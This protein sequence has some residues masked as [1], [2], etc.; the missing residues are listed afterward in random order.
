MSDP[1]VEIGQGK[2]KGHILKDDL[3]NTYYTFRGIPYA[4]PPIGELRFAAPEPPEPW[5]GIKDGSKECNICA[6]FDVKAKVFVGDEDCL[7]LNVSMRKLPRDN[8]SLLPVM[9]FLHGGGFVFGNGTDPGRHGPDYLVGKDVVIVT[10]NYRLGALG[11]LSLECKEAPGNVGLKDQ[12]QA[13]KWV[14]QNIKNFGGDP[15]N[16]TLFGMSAGA[17]A[18]EYHLLSPM[19]KGLFHKAISNSGSTL[20]H[21]AHSD[22][23]KIKGFARKMASFKGKFFENDSEL[24]KYLKQLP[25]RELIDATMYI[26]QTEKF[27][28]GANFIFAPAVEKLGDWEPFLNNSPYLK[29]SNGEFTKVPVMT[30]INQREGLWTIYH[31]LDIINNLSKEKNFVKHFPFHL[32][33]DEIDEFQSKLKAMYLDNQNKSEETDSFA[34]DFFTDVDFLGGIY[35]SAMLKA[36]YGCP[37]YFYEFVYDGALN[38]LKKVHGISRKGAAHAD[39]GGYL[40]KC[41]K[42]TGTLSDDDILI[43]NMMVEMWTNFAK[44]G[45]P[46][47]QTDSLITTKW[48]PINTSGPARLVI[49]KRLSM[50]Y[51]I[52]PERTKFYEEVYCKQFGS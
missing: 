45:N 28:G 39:D 34:I 18:V 40:M 48:E 42:L 52:Y 21:W 41:N 2:I 26:L 32:N 6:Q 47:P 15:N 33:P 24:L 11:F 35:V 51:E 14:Q 44:N 30:G 3:G 38:F 16:V 13:L 5:D 29:L 4:K 1:I 12:V 19:S 10:I 23:D 50:E 49:D 7:Y 43:R 25:I 8:S 36:K 17:A 20:L 22:A 37:V 31:S 27:K 46:T 9:F